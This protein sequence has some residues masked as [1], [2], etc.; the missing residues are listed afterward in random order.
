MKTDLQK[1]YIE[2]YSYVHHKD[3]KSQIENYYGH[4][5]QQMPD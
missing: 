3:I 5:L 2:F 1:G 4:T